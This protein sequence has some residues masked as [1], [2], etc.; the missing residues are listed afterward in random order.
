VLNKKSNKM[1]LT[2]T[3]FAR[4][5]FILI[6]L[7][8]SCGSYAQTRKLAWSDEF[9]GTTIDRSVW[10]FD[11]GPVNDCVH[12]FTD[13]PE[14]A[15]IEGG[16]LRIIAL[17]ESY[18]GFNYTSALLKTKNSV[19]WRYGR[20]EARIKLPGT[21]GFVPAFWMM[22][23]DDQYGWWPWSGE[24]DIME[25]P[26]NQVDKIF[27]TIHCGAYDT[28]TGTEPKGS[29]I[30]IPDAE[31]AYHVYAIEWT[32]EKIDFYVDDQK[33]F[34]FNNENSGFKAWPFDQPFY[35]IL[36]L[37]VGGGWVGN[38]D[39]T[40]VF[41]AV[42]EV[43]YVRVYQY[44][45]DMNITGPDFLTYN[46]QSATYTFP[47]LD[48]AGYSWSLPGHA[49]ILSGE[50][51][52]QIQAV[53]NIFGGSVNVGVQTN[54]GSYNV[55]YPVEVSYNLLKNSGFEKGVK[56]WNCSIAS[57]ADATAHL[58]TLN[59]HRG[60]SSVFVE[61]KA[62]ATNGWDVQISQRDLSITNG[63]QYKASFWAKTDGAASQL[64]AAVINT[65]DYTLYA[66]NTF[67]VTGSW[68]QFEMIFTA[69]AS[70]PVGFNV[71]LGSNAGTFCLDD[72]VFTTPE[73]SDFNQLTNPDFERG[74]DDWYFN[75]L[76][77]AQAN[78]YVSDG[79]SAVSIDNGGTNTWDIHLG[80]STV[81]AEQ[82][83]EYTVSFDAYAA[84]P[85]NIF[86]FVGKNADPW[87]VY[88]GNQT[89]S[90]STTKQAY[91]YSFIMTETSDLQARFGFDIGA[92][93]ADVFL[94]NVF[95]SEGKLPTNTDPVINPVPESSMLYQ[96]YPNPFYSFTTI[97]YFLDKPSNVS[98]KIFNAVGK[99]IITLADGYQTAG[100]HQVKWTA[101]DFAGGVYLCRLQTDNYSETKKL[102]LQKR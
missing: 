28:Y 11:K 33:Y 76:L 75:T 45:Q 18:E 62:P 44:E 86:A 90:L 60:K 24:I 49:E 52:S 1:N 89:F 82:G 41:P 78:S 25:H 22:P 79:E 59:V 29:N 27:G 80:Q 101:E 37:A 99:E 4:L 21:N 30:Q 56:Y 58:D 61:V 13:R 46:N 17:K 2:K 98:L 15:A 10:S 7:I 96:I 74:M 69:N 87:T 20:I 5:Y 81:S 102:L 71:D 84:E 55:G 8:C 83:K 88:S 34:T 85:R 92:S 93:S 53:W 67:P 9:N 48:G 65:V 31:N 64:S 43:D 14:N 6:I 19:N 39:A 3:S 97:Q 42:M 47:T 91:T 40:S 73:L 66:N 95:L 54:E 72:F 77:P 26:T 32:P 16:I 35:I 12:Y 36:N 94:D 38:P 100:E 68:T 50:N 51:T 70:A 57:T 23:A 63:K